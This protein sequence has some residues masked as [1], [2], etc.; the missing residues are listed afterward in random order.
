MKNY[1]ALSCIVA[2]LGACANTLTPTQVSEAQTAI[3]LLSATV[4][5]LGQFVAD[6]Q[7]ICAGSGVFQAIVDA[8]TNKPFLVT[9]KAA[10]TVHNICLALGAT[11]VSSPGPLVPIGTAVVTL[12]PSS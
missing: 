7:L 5:Q 11:P 6:G 9:G 4:P 12:P 3:K 10:N 1:V 8:V 2:M